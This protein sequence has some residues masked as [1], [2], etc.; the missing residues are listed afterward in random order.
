MRSLAEA[1][2]RHPKSNRW[3]LD[4][5]VGRRRGPDHSSFVILSSLGISSFDIC[6][7]SD[8][9]AQLFDLAVQAGETELQAF[10]GFAFVG[11]LAEHAGDVQLFVVP[12][13]RSQVV[14]VGKRLS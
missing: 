12:Q 10:G 6:R 9:N 3:C 8:I 2:L 7:R 11:P 14:S 1:E 4:A 13:R 5:G